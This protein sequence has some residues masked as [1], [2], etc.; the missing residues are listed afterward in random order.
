M[1]SGFLVLGVLFNS[2]P[3]SVHPPKHWSYQGS[4]EG[5]LN[6]TKGKGASA[7]WFRLLCWCKEDKTVTVRIKVT[8]KLLGGLFGVLPFRGDWLQLGGTSPC[9]TLSLFL[10]ALGRSGGRN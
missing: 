2:T 7:A 10:G 9:R 5:S 6:S 4:S 1:R 8:L 3:D